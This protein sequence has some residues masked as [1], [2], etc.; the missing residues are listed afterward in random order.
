VTTV[1]V[2]NL[3]PGAERPFAGGNRS[4]PHGQEQVLVSGRYRARQ[5]MGP[6]SINGAISIEV[7]YCPNCGGELTII[8]A[9][10]DRPGIEKV[11]AHLA[12]ANPGTAAGT[13]A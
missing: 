2:S 1:S 9:T 13:C 3:Q 6:A 8:A 7:A 10:P 12:P 5:L 4:A 11:L